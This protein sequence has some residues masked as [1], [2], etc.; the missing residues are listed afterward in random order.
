MIPHILYPLADTVNRPD[1]SVEVRSGLGRGASWVERFWSRFLRGIRVRLWS[2]PRYIPAPWLCMRVPSSVR[3]LHPPGATSSSLEVSVRR[4]A[5]CSERR[6]EASL[7]RV[8][9]AHTCALWHS[10]DLLRC[11]SVSP[12][13][14]RRSPLTPRRH[15]PRAQESGGDRKPTGTSTIR[16]VP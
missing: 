9:Q 6:D 8:P 16:Y 5:Q 7:G 10:V 2:K 15:Q 1:D 12:E 4:G 11:S 14:S 3:C 13:F